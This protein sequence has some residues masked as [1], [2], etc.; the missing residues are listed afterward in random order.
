MVLLKFS[1][2]ALRG[3]KGFWGSEWDFWGSVLLV[4]RDFD[5]Y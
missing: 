2:W 3:K 4:L 1:F 5:I